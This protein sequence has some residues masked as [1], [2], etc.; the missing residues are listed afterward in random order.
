MVTGDRIKQL[1]KSKKLSQKALGKAT[2]I[3]PSAI[4]HY[5]TGRITPK[6]H[7]LETLAAFFNVS[8]SYLEGES[9]YPELEELMNAEF[10]GEMTNG[11]FLNKCQ[12]LDS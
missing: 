8:V 6:R 4:S 7:R 9:P 3:S 5:E 10:Y 1:R 2:F 11:D 12:S